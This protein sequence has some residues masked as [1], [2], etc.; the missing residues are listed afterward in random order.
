MSDAFAFLISGPGITGMQNIALVPGTTLN[1]EIDNINTNTNNQYYVNNNGGASVQYD[2]FTTVLTATMTVT[3]CST[4][5]MKIVIADY[6]DG[7]YDSGVF[8]EKGGISCGTPELV[9]TAT[10]A[11]ECCT[12]GTFVF[13]LDQPQANPLTVD[14]TLSGS[15]TDGTDYTGLSG[16]V[17]FPAGQTTVTVPVA[18][19]CDQLT[20][21]QETIELFIGQAIC[22][23]NL[24]ASAILTIS[25]G[26]TID[27]GPDQVIC[28]NSAQLNA[29]GTGTF[30][31]SPGTG[32][33]CTA[34]QN[35][36]ATPTVTTT[37]MVTLTDANGCT[38]TDSVT[39]AVSCGPILTA[40]GDEFCEEDCG[41]VEAFPQ[42][43]VAPYAFTWNPNIGTTAGPHQVCP[44]STTR[45]YVTVTDNDGNSDTASAL[46]IVNPLPNLTTSQVNPICEGLC[47]GTATVTAT[48]SGSYI[49][50]WDDPS[51]QSGATATGLCVGTY[52]VTVTDVNGCISTTSV[53]L[54]SPTAINLSVTGTDAS[55][56]GICDATATV[57]ATGGSLPHSYLW[58]D[59]AAQTTATAT[60]LCAGNHTVI[61]TDQNGCQA[62]IQMTLNEPAPVVLSTSQT[63]VSCFG[64]CDGTGTAIASGGQGTL[65]YLWND[66]AVQTSATATGLCPGTWTVTVTDANGCA[67]N[68]VVVITEPPALVLGENHFNVKCF[69]GNDGSVDLNVTGGTGNINVLWDSGQTTEDLWG[70]TAGTYCVTVNDAN[71]CTAGL[72][73]DITEP[74]VIVLDPLST[75]AT[76]GNND[77]TVSVSVSSG[78]TAPFS[79]RWND[80]SSQATAAISG[81]PPG[82]YCVTITDA[83]ACTDTI[84]VDVPDISVYPNVCF[85][86]SIKACIP[87]TVQFVNCS[88][89]G[90]CLWDFGDG[91]SSTDC[92]PTHT[93]NEARCYDITLSVTSPEGCEST[94]TKTCYIEGYPWPSADFTADPWEVNVFNPT[95][96]FFD[97]STNATTWLWDFGDDDS[98]ATQNPVHTYLDTG[99]FPVT[100][101][102]ENQY[103]CTDDVVKQVCVKDIHA[104]YVPNAF[105]PNGDGDNDWFAAK[106]Y[107]VCDINMFI[108]DRWGNQIYQTSSL[109]GWDGTANGGTDI[110]EE[111]VY[112][113]VIRA[114]FCDG[115]E[116]RRVG[117][118]TLIK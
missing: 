59:P 95:I 116:V 114:R 4:Y 77:G 10:D 52:Q 1:V 110:A 117:H 100:L 25:D 88:D 47:D 118:V 14:Y 39:V 93:F 109:A 19:I 92:N 76:C 103:G 41:N 69:G 23:G 12:D 96:N 111:D 55:C 87:V 6:G 104:L 63:P 38:V 28:T 8:L 33:S 13:T 80:G 108:F 90:T 101:Y 86:D 106:E 29:T 15:A 102:L 89:P 34:C 94:L 91:T 105:T 32:L 83:N 99:C 61:V 97:K 82:V 65:S 75:P 115:D 60:G 16:S 35:P 20:E 24:D 70:V 56:N 72:C 2:A 57:T 113:W 30:V 68:E 73:V 11:V 50:Q 51:S 37:Y 7:I 44:A 43:G 48:G 49:Y 46:V 45:Y 107:G 36:V 40:T 78:G 84:C 17:T 62:S 64:A 67:F 27:A 98:S 112:V 42:G 71:G 58:D 85:S 21:G 22:G 74:D 53:T 5:H 18:V 66:P 9:V 3:P 31:W 26:P 79:Y 81:L 54:S